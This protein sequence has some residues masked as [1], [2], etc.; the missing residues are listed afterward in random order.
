MKTIDG[1]IEASCKKFSDKVAIRHKECGHWQETSY[2]QLWITVCQI[3]AGLQARGVVPGDRIALLGSNSPYW[4]SSYLGILRC[5]GIVV[6][7]DKD[8]KSA[9]MRHVLDD[10]GA[11]LLICEPSA[12]E[13]IADI[14]GDLSELKGV[15]LFDMDTVKHKQP[16]LQEKLKALVAAWRHLAKQFSIPDKDLQPLEYLS[17][18][19]QDMAGIDIGERWIGR[20]GATPD[21]ILPKGC[22]LSLFSDLLKDELPA[23]VRRDADDTAVILYTSGTTGR[24]KGAMLSHRNIVSNIENAIPQMGADH[25]MHTLSFLPINHVFEQVA[26]TLAPLSLGGTVSIAE[27]IKKIAQNLVE[28]QP[29]YFMG[30]PAVYRLLF[31]RIMKNISEKP[32][33]RTLFGMSLTRP[34]IA[35]KVR[36][37][38][39]C[40]PTFI[41]GG[42]ALDPEIALGMEKLG[43]TLHQGY[44]ITET[45]PIISVEC[46]GAKKLGSVG[47]SIPGVEVRINAPNKEGV[48]EILVRGDNVMQ[49]YY[50]RPQ[51]T[52]EAIK[53][54]WYHTGD[55]GRLDEEGLLYICGRL[56]NLIV[57]PNGKNVYPEEVEN[58]LLKSPLIA[59]VMV[60]GHRI[61]ATAEEVHAQIYPDQDA[62]DAY[63]AREGIRPLNQD[64]VESLLRQE[65]LQAGQRLA[66]YKRIK[67]F[68]LRDDE[69]PKTTTRKIK[70]FAVEADIKTSI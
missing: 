56:K 8:L 70:R 4:I 34:L 45:S 33:A 68:T 42:A 53:D 35:A 19:I 54:G 23:A 26:G 59:E 1:F 17:R 3:A 40:S 58:E 2:R 55:L 30:V 37:K 20:A 62:L 49:G 67:R 48:G 29:T 60:Y 14:A 11:R 38:L 39:G 63:A 21:A 25:T 27:S 52:A 22:D 15:V 47:R 46:P 50:R 32:L 28:V 36:K 6:P 51:A 57:T 18:E 5:G 41:S 43:F 12:L 64:A 16:P 31:N 61:D 9:E 65:V 10:C 44:G 69:F 24:S 7:V 66:D 13:I